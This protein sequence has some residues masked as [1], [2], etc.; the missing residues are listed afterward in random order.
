MYPM[1]FV[2][3]V[4][5]EDDFPEIIGA[6]LKSANIESIHVKKRAEIIPKA[7]E[8]KPDLILMDV[9]MPEG[10]GS[11][12]LLDLQQN[13]GTKDMKVA[14]LTNSKEPW[15]GFTGEQIDVA[16]E[17]GAVDFLQKTD[18]LEV[19]LTRIQAILSGEKP[20]PAAEVVPASSVAPAAAASATPKS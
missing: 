10:Q 9:N 12:I 20:V 1:A 18:D 3:I 19:L 17:L 13:D 15:P 2:L 11:E 16:K 4:D 5:D 7:I 6:K 14:F 8:K